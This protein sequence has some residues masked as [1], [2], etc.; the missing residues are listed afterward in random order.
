MKDKLKEEYRQNFK[1]ISELLTFLLF[2]MNKFYEGRGYSS[3]M[4]LP[5]KPIGERSLVC[6]GLSHTEDISYVINLHKQNKTLLY[7]ICP[8]N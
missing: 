8:K 7:K 5:I 2:E 1:S 3:F 6:I 4:S